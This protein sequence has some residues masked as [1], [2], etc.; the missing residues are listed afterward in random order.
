MLIINSR[1][2]IFSTILLGLSRRTF[3][4]SAN[5]SQYS[6]VYVTTPNEEVAKK[7][8]HG[9]V[10]GKL[11]ACANIIPKITSIYEW[12]N[13]INEDSEALMMI[14]TRTSKVDELTDFVKANHPYQVCEVIAVPIFKG[15]EAYLKWIG[16]VVPEK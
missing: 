11:A 9:L 4:I 16:E 7:I 10:Q 6:A 12:E 1:Y 8:A 14:K 3:S 15:N 2:L 5:M 13:K